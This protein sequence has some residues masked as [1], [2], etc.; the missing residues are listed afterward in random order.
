[1]PD[2]A[3]EGHIPNTSRLL[4]PSASSSLPSWLHTLPAWGLPAGVMPLRTQNLHASCPESQYLM[5]DAKALEQPWDPFSQGLVCECL[6]AEL[7]N[8]LPQVFLCAQGSPET[9]FSG[10]CLSVDLKVSLHSLQPMMKHGVC[11]QGSFSRF[12]G[13]RSWHLFKELTASDPIFPAYHFQPIP[14]PASFHEFSN[15]SMLLFS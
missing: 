9:L 11:P 6:G 1:M 13:R 4:F 12:P 8:K 2:S 3:A 15:C 7:K 14:F 10:E 5:L